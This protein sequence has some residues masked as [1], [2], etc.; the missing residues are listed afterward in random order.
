MNWDN[1]E[2]YDPGVWGPWRNLPRREARSAYNKLMKAKPGRIAM[3]KE[4]LQASDVVLKPSDEG[5]QMLNDWY[6]AN[7]EADPERPGSLSARWYSVTRDV[8]L[9]LG[10]VVIARCPALRWQLY[11]GGKRAAS[12]QQPV[13]T[14]FP[15]WPSFDINPGWLVSS[16]GHRIIASRGSVAH[17]GTVMV[18][19]IEV[20]LNAR[21]DIL[22]EDVELNWF[23]RIVTDAVSRG[24]GEPQ[25][26]KDLLREPKAPENRRR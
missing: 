7:I 18:R 8:A 12:Y 16:Y 3:L 17:E 5:I 26:L 21:P 2:L 20:N 14:G 4:L 24:E 10:D 6:L 25:Q 15:G 23:V 19:G 22:Q 11:T 1:Y 13:L 9:F